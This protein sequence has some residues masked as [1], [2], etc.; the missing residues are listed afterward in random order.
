MTGAA[1]PVSVVVAGGS[2]TGP[3]GA[4]TGATAGLPACELSV[5]ADGGGGSEPGADTTAICSAVTGWNDASKVASLWDGTPGTP[6]TGAST[7]L[8]LSSMSTVLSSKCTRDRSKLIVVPS[9][10]NVPVTTPPEQS[11]AG[12]SDNVPGPPPLGGAH[13]AE[14]AAMGQT[15]IAT[16][17]CGCAWATLS[18]TVCTDSPSARVKRIAATAWAPLGLDPTSKPPLGTCGAAGKDDQ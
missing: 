4:G 3:A 10:D 17:F 5:V 14:R 13:D 8:G 1:P 16:W 12:A 2:D 15:L 7:R 18:V 6:P 11:N 9:E